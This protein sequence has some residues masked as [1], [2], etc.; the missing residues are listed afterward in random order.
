MYSIEE[1]I[2]F[3]N[4]CEFLDFKQ[5]EYNENNKPHL[6]KD[7]LAFA[8]SPVK[9][10]RYIV[11]GVK[12][13][14]GEIALFNIESNTD[15]AHIQQYIH[16]NI[17]P[18]IQ[19]SYTSFS[20]KNFNLMILAIKNPGEQP[21]MTSKDVF[22]KNGKLALKANECW[23][24]KGSYQVMATR[25]DFERIYGARIEQ[26]DFDGIIT[27]E[28]SCNK[29]T[30]LTIEP[31]RNLEFPS[32]KAKEKLE[33]IIAHKEGL[34]SRNDYQYQASIRNNFLA[35][36]EPVPYEN[37]DI[38]TLKG[39][40]EKVSETYRDDDYF[41]LF[42]E[43]A[44]KL[45]LEILNTGE[46]YLEDASISLMIP[47]LKK[48]L[49]AEKVY[50]IHREPRNPMI[51]YSPR[52]PKF[53]ELNYPEV[54]EEEGFYVINAMLGDIKHNISTKAFKAP[55]RIAFG[56]IPPGTTLPVQCIIYGRNLRNPLRK[57]LAIIIK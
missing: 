50:Y 4:E 26:Q 18:D 31:L 10:D 54:K 6:I 43:M 46:A 24:R 32:K 27:V 9:G 16:A 40:L 7:V 5:E 20:Y 44:F 12:K 45:N 52:T 35:I 28:F 38:E 23:V 39:N 1:L 8:N 2:E 13:K 57:E 42:E 49:I 41:Y 48:M 33:K 55:I 14:D 11:I 37:R 29:S 15:S 22:Y 21:Y 25:S 51:P 17:T 34:K 19:V 56:D 30:S 36:W 53:D 47:K 3:H